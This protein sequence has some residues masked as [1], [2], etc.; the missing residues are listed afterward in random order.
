[1]TSKFMSLLSSNLDLAFPLSS[2]SDW[3]EMDL[4]Q[5][6]KKQY[7]L[8]SIASLFGTKI[9]ED[10][11]GDE[12]YAWLWAFDPHVSTLITQLPDILIR[13][14]AR[15]REWGIKML[16]EWERAAK[17]ATSDA[18]EEGR[19][20]DENWGL[21]FCKER[22]RVSEEAGISERGRA[23]F[24]LALL[25][26]QNANAIPVSTWLA[27]QALAPANAPHLPCIISSI[28]D[29][30]DEVGVS[31]VQELVKKPNL[32]ALL[33][34]T[35]R[36]SVASPGVRFVKTDTTL[37]GYDLLAGSTILIH[38]RTLQLDPATWGPDA[39][40]FSPSRFLQQ[41]NGDEKLKRVKAASQRH[42]GGGQN[43][44]PGRHFA[45]NEILG[46]F[47]VLMRKF[48]IEVDEGMLVWRGMPECEVSAGKQ[49]GL[50]PDRPFMVRM[51]RR[52]D[53]RTVD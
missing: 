8:A 39:T 44:C 29:S 10:G 2:S 11:K 3:R 53:R 15:S 25:W 13:H 45:C 12:I 28:S 33:K 30:V 18:G 21:A 20:W 48:E 31:D 34:E 7:T 26:G 43:H 24:Q 40:M 23:A 41:D 42:F 52:R 22:A 46:G 27:I 37:G 5:F 16:I 51:K 14:A 32:D 36:W 47:A 50:W 1:M 49:G 9:L 4:V 35:Y 6:I 38:A 19:I 17:A